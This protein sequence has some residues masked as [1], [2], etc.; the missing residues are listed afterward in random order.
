MNDQPIPH[1]LYHYTT[2][3][4]LLGILKERALFATKIRYFD[5]SNELIGP[6]RIALDVLAKKQQEPE[7]G[8]RRRGI[9]R[10][11]Q[12]AIEQSR[13]I[14]IPTVSFT[15]QADSEHLWQ[16]HADGGSGYAIG[17][18]SGKL[19]S[20]AHHLT[21]RQCE[22]RS[23]D[24]QREMIYSLIASELD[25]STPPGETPLYFR[26]MTIAV[27]MKSEAFAAEDEWRL[28]PCSCNWQDLLNY[29]YWT[30][31]FRPGRQGL[32]PYWLLPID[33]SAITEIVVGPVLDQELAV[34][35]V[36]GLMHRFQLSESIRITVSKSHAS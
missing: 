15:A 32:R 22:Y 24:M 7:L 8:D 25:G 16:E 11:T 33:L 18:D 26:L 13:N 2:Q 23:Y 3:E 28:V 12:W 30:C 4:G 36:R 9:V 29:T 5:D 21:L 10:E 34:D 35:G 20:P 14:N 6:L 1:V 31:Q 17:L 19:C 27:T